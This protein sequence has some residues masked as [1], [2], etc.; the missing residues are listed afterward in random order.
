KNALT[1][2]IDSIKT[3]N[4]YEFDGKAAYSLGQGQ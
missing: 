3:E 4:L 2:Q 1:H